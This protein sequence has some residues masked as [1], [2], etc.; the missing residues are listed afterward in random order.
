MMVA[1]ITVDVSQWLEAFQVLGPFL[2]IALFLSL[3]QGLIIAR[4]ND[5]RLRVW[6][7]AACIVLIIASCATALFVGAINS[8]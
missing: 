7:Q 4:I 3:V 8:F 6:S 5:R 2:G 1:Q